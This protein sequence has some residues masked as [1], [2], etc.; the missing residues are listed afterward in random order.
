ME[1]P[2]I[3]SPSMSGSFALPY[4]LTHPESSGEGCSGYIP[5]APVGTEDYNPAQYKACTVRCESPPNISPPPKKK[6]FF[7]GEGEGKLVA[8]LD[9]N[10]PL[11]EIS[12]YRVQLKFK[13]YFFLL[14][15]NEKHEI[16]RT[17]YIPFLN[18]STCAQVELVTCSPSS[19]C[20]D[21]NVSNR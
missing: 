20:Y 4:L 10:K 2:V 13:Y 18:L 1:R 19:V 8:A 6:D 16:N 12:V 5:I 21:L 3:V 14:R 17:F 15:Q 11:L 7:E 9:I